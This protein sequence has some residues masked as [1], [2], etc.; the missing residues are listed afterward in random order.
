MNWT[1]NSLLGRAQDLL[2]FFESFIF[3]HIY[4]EAN[5]ITDQMENLGAN[6]KNSKRVLALNRALSIGF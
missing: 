1:L 5:T 6:R 3:N 2:K 4:R